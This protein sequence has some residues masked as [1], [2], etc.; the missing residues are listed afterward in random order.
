MN[1]PAHAIANLLL[2]RRDRERHALA[3]TL[4]AFAPDLPMVAF[5][6][7]GRGQGMSERQ[8]WRDGYFDPVW[9]GVFDIVHSFPLLALAW[10]AV[11]RAGWRS[12]AAFI[13]S[14][15][16]HACFDFPLHHDDAHHQFFPFSDWRFESPVSYWDPA[17]HGRL[18]APLELL[19]VVAGGAWLLRTAHSVRLRRL[20]AG[21]MFIYLAWWGFVAAMWA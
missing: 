17:W 14:M 9:Q 7:W 21:V 15:F 13:A 4:G 19:L 12:A 3:I 1:T 16:L 20:T 2:L 18:V 6:A 8:L 11:W 5:W 10:L